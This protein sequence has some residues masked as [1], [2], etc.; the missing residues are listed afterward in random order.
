VALLCIVFTSGTEFAPI[1]PANALLLAAVLRQ[2][3]GWL[4]LLAGTGA[5][6]LAEWAARGNLPLAAAFTF[7]NVVEVIAAAGLLRLF[8]RDI[9]DLTTVKGLTLF[10]VLAA[11]APP[12]LSATIATA[13]VEIG[14]PTGWRSSFVTWF[15][16]DA[17]GIAIV[18]PFALILTREHW[19]RVWT[20]Q[21]AADAATV[22]AFVILVGAVTAYSRSLFFLWVPVTLLAAFRLGVPGAAAAILMTAVLGTIYI[23]KGVGVPLFSDMPQRII[24]F[25]LFMAANVF[26]ALPVA[27]M[28][29]ENQRLLAQV[30]SDNL[31]LRSA[32]IRSSQILTYLHRNLMNAEER[33]RLRLARELHDETGQTL[34]ATMVQLKQIEPFVAADGRDRL[35]ALHRMLEQIG[36]TLHSIAWQLRPTS[37]NDCGLVRALANYAGEWKG[38]FGVDVDFH[39]AD[40]EIDR[41]PEEIRIAV[42]RVVQEA[43]TNVGKHAAGATIV[44]IVIERLDNVLH[45]TIEDDGCG[46]DPDQIPTQGELASAGGLGLAGMRERMALLSGELTVQSRPGGGTTIFARISLHDQGVSS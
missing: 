37:I 24:A 29:S 25:Q 33:E 23:L 21:G 16:S 40:R 41:L 12:A 7:A 5:L 6:L 22:L 38:R 27:A 28:T 18:A 43:L 1:W 42:Y 46:F 11:L 30:S 9:P 31:R 36:K 3:P 15:A 8:Y 34:A 17:L 26:W 39:C 13:T 14:G 4:S 20:A 2:H 45:L 19:S 35:D 10:L 32:S 44:S